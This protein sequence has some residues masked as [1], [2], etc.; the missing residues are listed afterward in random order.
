MESCRKKQPLSRFCLWP[1]AL[2]PG[3]PLQR[4]AGR[5]LPSLPP[6]PGWALTAGIPFRA[7]GP[8]LHRDQSPRLR[9]PPSNDPGAVPALGVLGLPARA[10]DGWV[11]VSTGPV[12]APLLDS[13][14]PRATSRR[15]LLPRGFP[16]KGACWRFNCPHLLLFLQEAKRNC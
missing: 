13:S 6:R 8:A 4:G 14:S 3:A 7:P 12:S 16:T 10:M 5:G 11:G 2:P 9:A 15:F 1:A